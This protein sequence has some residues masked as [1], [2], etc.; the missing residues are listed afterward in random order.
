MKKM[1]YSIVA[2]A[3]L[4]TASI[5]TACVGKTIYLGISS[6]NENLIA[7]MASLMISERTGSAVKVEV[8][9]DSKSLY[10][11]I[12]QG[13]VNIIIENTDHARE[14]LGKAKGSPSPMGTDAIKSEYRKSMNLVWLNSYGAPLQYAPVLTGDTLN[15]YP[16]LPKLL[17]KLAGALPNDTYAKLL[18]LLTSEDK[19]KKVARDFLKGKKL[20]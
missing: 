9:K 14:V 12:K 11:A 20:I 17:N 16:A 19:T 15:S 2:V 10:E 6:A 7:E 5:S 13:R 3:F 4:V 18:K 8:Y 1:I